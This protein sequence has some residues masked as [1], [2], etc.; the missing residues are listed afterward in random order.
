M[1]LIYIAAALALA[2][3]IVNRTAIA[4]R[5]VRLTTL[6]ARLATLEA[7]EEIREMFSRY[8][9]AADTG[10]A[11]GWSETWAEN[12]VYQRGTT[13]TTGRA[14]FFRSIED[15]NGTHKREIEGKGSVHTTG[16]LMI[17]VAGEKAWA[18]GPALVWV[19][20]A[21]GYAVYALSYNHWELQ[22]TAGRWEIVRRIG[23]P[24]APGV[25]TDVLK[26]WRETTRVP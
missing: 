16:P 20:S 18:E 12:A 19:R 7:K 5:P 13:T 10:D 26:S 25:A 8:G 22:K 4:A 9:F 17:R 11:A 2:L 3:G 23:R 21:E 6:E 24:V 14:A 15:P 1:R